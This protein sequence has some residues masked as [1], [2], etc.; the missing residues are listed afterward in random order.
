MSA[1]ASKVLDK[2][3]FDWEVYKT[4]GRND[5]T[6]RARLAV[7]EKVDVVVAVGGDGTINEVAKG[8]QHS[9]TALGVIPRGSGN[10]FANYFGI[11]HDPAQAI[12]RLNTAKVQRID[13]GEFNNKPFLNV[14]GLGFDAHIAHAFDNYGKRGLLS[15]AWLTIKGYMRFQPSNY[16]IKF[17]K[18]ELTVKAM[19]VT[20]ANSSQFGNDAFIAPQ[21]KIDDGQLQLVILR[22]FPLWYSPMLTIRLFNKSFHN[23]RFVETIPSKQFII[24]STDKISQVDGEPIK[25]NTENKIDIQPKSLKVFT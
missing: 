6:H 25:C 2:K 9:E 22:P 13:V 14:A 18:N 16:V 19:M 15:Y 8:L 17:D 1:I 20:A 12:K 24:Q 21:A 11:P 7:D 10:G 5:A 3:Q 4:Q 23:S